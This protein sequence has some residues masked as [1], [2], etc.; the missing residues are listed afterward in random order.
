MKAGLAAIIV[1]IAM[2]GVLRRRRHERTRLS[3]PRPLRTSFLATSSSIVEA[4]AGI[5][6][7]D[8]TLNYHIAGRSISA[9]AKPDF[10]KKCVQR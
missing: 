9:L 10:L 8:V 2:I 7:T 3:Q 5:E 4:N 6:I 1:A